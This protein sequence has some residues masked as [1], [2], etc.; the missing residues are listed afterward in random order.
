[1][2]RHRIPGILLIASLAAL[3]G[4]GGPG[5]SVWVTGKVLK[6]GTRFSPPEGHVIGVTFYAIDSKG[7]E[8]DIKFE[9]PSK[10]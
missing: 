8:V 3:P 10:E 7:V 5:N 1:M 9:E 2:H 6:G 4:C